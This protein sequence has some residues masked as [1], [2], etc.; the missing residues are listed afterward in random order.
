M[1][2]TIE[3]S[4]SYFGIKA[5]NHCTPMFYKK[6]PYSDFKKMDK[7]TVSKQNNTYGGAM[8]DYKKKLEVQLKQL[9]SLIKQSN[10]NI[11]KYKDIGNGQIH[12][13]RCR[14]NWQYY[15]I[16]KALGIRQYMGTAQ[17]KTIR[18]YIQKDYELTLNK[19]LMELQ[20]RLQKFVS[21][22][23]INEITDVYDNLPEG[24]KKYVVPLIESDDMYIERWLEQHPGNQNTYPQKGL[25]QTNHGE[26]VRSKSEKIIADALAK[27]KVPYQYESMLELGYSTVY[28]DFVALNLRTRKTIYWEHL[29]M[30]S[31]IEYAVKNFKKIQD[32]EKY[33]Y[34]QGRDLIITI[35][36][37]EEP[38][39]VKLVEEKIREFLL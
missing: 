30:T 19:K 13:S 23:D 4:Y 10:K 37:L 26:M 8:E 21:V 35:E 20:K 38:I 31:D 15:Y 22:Y 17:E 7:K 27:Y 32:Y 18:K 28:P 9:N 5:E 29:G 14:G 6:R 36:S 33:G 3:F 11:A 1:I 24:R 39:D 12:I 34:W 2:F 25:Y 16:D